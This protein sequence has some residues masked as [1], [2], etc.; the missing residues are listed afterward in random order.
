MA[1]W[2]Q[3]PVLSPTT[4]TTYNDVDDGE[5]N[6]RPLPLLL[7]TYGHTPEA[8]G[9]AI[10]RSGLDKSLLRE[11]YI[12]RVPAQLVAASASSADVVSGAGSAALAQPC[13]K[14]DLASDSAVHQQ[15]QKQE[16]ATQPV[17]MD[18]LGCCSGL[19]KLRV[20]YAGTTV[21]MGE[22]YA[23]SLRSLP[24]TVLM[25]RGPS[26]LCV[27]HASLRTVRLDRCGLRT[28]DVLG[29]L[30]S[31]KEAWLAENPLLTNEGVHGL[32]RSTSLRLIDLNACELLSSGPAALAS[33][34]TLEELRLSR[35]RITNDTIRALARCPRLT[36]LHINFCGQVTD[37]NPLAE[38]VT[39]RELSASRCAIGTA[40]I[41][42]FGAESRRCLHLEHL[43]LTENT[44]LT[45]AAPLAA[46]TSLRRLLLTTTSISNH[47]FEELDRRMTNQTQDCLDRLEV[48][49]LGNARQV[50]SLGPLGRLPRLR[51]LNI[52]MTDMS[53]NGLQGLEQ[54]RSLARLSIQMCRF[55]PNTVTSLGSIPTLRMVDWSHSSASNTLVCGLSHSRSLRELHLMNCNR[56]SDVSNLRDLP[57]LRLLDLSDTDINDS[58]VNALSH[59][60]LLRLVDLSGCTHV[61]NVNALGQVSSLRHL[62]ASMTMV[63]TE[64]LHGLANCHRLTQLMLNDCGRIEELRRVLVAPSLRR[65][66]VVG[67][68]LHGS[69]ALSAPAHVLQCS[70]LTVLDLSQNSGLTTVAELACLPKLTYLDISSTA[71]DDAALSGMLSAAFSRYPSWP[72][73]VLFLAKLRGIVNVHYLGQCPHLTTLKLSESNMDDSGLEGLSRSRSLR[74]LEVR[75]CKSLRSLGPLGRIPTLRTIVAGGS[76]VTSEGVAGLSEVGGGRGKGRGCGLRC[77]RLFGCR[78]LTSFVAL[79]RLPQLEV[80]QLSNCTKLTEASIKEIERAE[81]AVGAVWSTVSS[82]VE[83]KE[84][85]AN[86]DARGTCCPRRQPLFPALYSLDLSY[87]SELTGNLRGLELLPRLRELSTVGSRVDM[88]V[89]HPSLASKET[90]CFTVVA[91]SEGGREGRAGL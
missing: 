27:L 9:K 59:F 64:G 87:C 53:H 91:V 80:L 26:V 31:L 61:T 44:S 79:G 12:L 1:W 25:L 35:S 17:L 71:V 34:P 41:V 18:A 47:F 72:L 19:T 48:L 38:C 69:A 58:T 90:A 10:Q 29:L 22:N 33:I 39:L 51:A 63:T 57:S 88:S 2:W 6:G 85:T 3:R 86:T 73:R 30:P 40:G 84:E 23:V 46:L 42:A 4:T 16:H 7:Y 89:V 55:L 37:I 62:N 15:E 52:D 78:N 43:T 74:Q 5:D 76:N 66:C 21:G 65:L 83:S 20:T 14:A 77:L 75:G 60:P 67:G 11:V 13:E 56:L 24:E 70:P 82:S 81:V 36:T 28:V 45:D 32:S 68:N 8:L 49:D 50:T 54:S